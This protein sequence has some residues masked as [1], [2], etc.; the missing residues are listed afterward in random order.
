MKFRF[1]SFL[2]S[3]IQ[4]KGFTHSKPLPPPLDPTFVALMRKEHQFLRQIP[5]IKAQNRKTINTAMQLS[6]N[7]QQFKL[8]K[9]HPYFTSTKSKE[10]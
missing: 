9:W 2:N 8:Q 7:M 3:T 1:D 6:N 5:N 10:N 4:F